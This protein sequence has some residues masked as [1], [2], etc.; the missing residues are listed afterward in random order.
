MLQLLFSLP[1]LCVLYLH[2]PVSLRSLTAGPRGYASWA[3]RPVASAPP[4]G[5]GAPGRPAG[6]DGP[7]FLG[8]WTERDPPII[9]PRVH[10][11]LQ[12][13]FHIVNASL[14]K[15]GRAIKYILLA[16]EEQYVSDACSFIITR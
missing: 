16:R 3:Q 6:S 15:S 7:R 10:G 2:A 8:G 14:T 4:D 9:L 11:A 5:V 12:L 1:K 13:A